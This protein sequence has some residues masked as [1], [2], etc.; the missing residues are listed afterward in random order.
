VLLRGSHPG[1][2]TLRSLAT[3][4]GLL[5][6]LGGCG[7]SASA[8]DPDRDPA[9]RSEAARLCHAIDRLREADNAQKGEWL[10]ALGAE[11]CTTLCQ[12]KQVC[13][14]AYQE[15]VSALDAI[16]EVKAYGSEPPAPGSSA[17]V[18]VTEKLSEAERRLRTSREKAEK[19]V[20][21]ESEAKRRYRL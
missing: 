2:R 7:K 15:H 3:C 11:P 17:G 19:C 5:G 6:A 12:L 10:K 14:S 8:D 4:V 20:E 13:E 1:F 21:S 16:R 18:Q 9:A